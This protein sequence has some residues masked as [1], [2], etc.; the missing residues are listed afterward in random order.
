LVAISLAAFVSEAAELERGS[1]VATRLVGDVEVLDRMVD[2][3]GSRALAA[4]DFDEDGVPDLAVAVQ[5]PSGNVLLVYRGNVDAV[6]RNTLVAKERRAVGEALDCPFLSSAR[7]IATQAPADSLHVGDFDADGHLDLLAAEVGGKSL[8]LHRGDGAGGFASASLIDLP[9]EL[10]ALT[11]GEVN[12]RDGLADV[13]AVVRSAEGAQ[14]L[15]FETPVGALAMPPETVDLEAEVVGL[16]LGQLDHQVGIDLAV[17]FE[18]GLLIVHGRDRQR[19]NTRSGPIPVTR[20]RVPFKVAALAIGDFGGAVPSQEGI[21]VL[22]DEGAVRLIVHTGEQ[23]CSKRTADSSFGHHAW[24]HPGNREWRLSSEIGRLETT[25]VMGGPV[26]LLRTRMAGSP[27]EGLVVVG[28]GADRFYL[29]SPADEER[30]QTAPSR[31]SLV[32]PASMSVAAGNGLGARKAGCEGDD[33]RWTAA[34]PRSMSISALSTSSVPRDV[35]PMRLNSDALQDFVVAIDGRTEP[36]FLITKADEIVVVD[37]TTDVADGATTSISDLAAD[38]GAD[39]VISLREAITA[40]NNTAGADAV[41]FDIP[42]DTDPGCNVGSGV[43]TIQPGGTGLPTITQPITIDGTTQPSFQATPV[44]EIDGSLATVDAT[45]IAIN[46]GSSVVRGLVINRFSGN[47]DIVMWGLGGN[48][49]EGNFLGVDASGTL[50]QGTTNSVHVYAISGNTIGG[51]TAAARNVISGNTNPAVAL[52]AGASSNSVKG[53]FIGTDLTGTVALGNSGNDIVTLDSPDNTI[54][55]TEA[56]AG[57]LV[58]GNL[59][60]DFA[61]IGLGFPASTGNLVQGNFVGTDVTGTVSRGGASIAVYITEGSSNTI[62]GTSPT[63][64]N[65]I[66]GGYSAGVGIASANGNTVQ[67]NYIGTQIDGS[68]SLPNASHGVLLY[69]GAA[70][71]TVGGRVDGARNI[72]ASN[73]ASGVELRGDAGVGNTVV[74]NSIS[75]NTDLG[76]NLCADYDSVNLVCNDAMLVTPNDPDDP[77]TGSNNL[78]NFPTLTSVIGGL[79]IEG[80]LDSIASSDFILDFYASPVCDPSGNGEGEVYLGSQP[81]TTDVNGDIAF[82]AH[83]LGDLQDGWVVTATATDV[84]GSTSEFSPCF[85]YVSDVIFADGFESG[86]VSAW[87]SSS[88]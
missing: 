36:V 80:A 58:S 28:A 8:H 55:G 45:G 7:V 34:T 50:N 44:I 75:A 69:A 49:V 43:C 27:T 30:V 85:S 87:T 57:N 25:S 31:S 77:D 78:Q 46:A 33:R 22:T 59:D 54:G 11:S 38:P 51:T 48:I 60:P 65:L 12:R 52:N 47:S 29:M 3:S 66:S 86:D 74:G 81:V 40:A 2:V 70:N 72:I 79:F 1:M 84:G 20:L 18:S 26:E 19:S 68:T 4:G 76:L 21:A 14:L 88:P 16:A 64:Y 41:H 17:A 13:V 62:G 53:N 35:V 39:G 63:A 83:L 32:P 9:G 67:G 10:T 82:T 73:G 71:N 37:S 23:D 56:G 6:Y 15:I 5:G 61:S 42:V 24:S